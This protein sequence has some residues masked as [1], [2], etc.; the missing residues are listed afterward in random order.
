MPLGRY[1]L[2]RILVTIVVLFGVSVLTFSMVQFLPGN[3]V[4][5]ILQ[6]Q[7][8]SPQLKQQL[9]AQ[10]HLND[11]I[12]QQYLYWLNDALHLNFGES[13]ISNRVV[14]KAILYRL[15]NTVA[16]GLFGFLIAVVIGIPAG[17]VA[18]V[19]KGELADEVSRVGALLGIATPNFW[20]GLILLL[21]FS[22]WLGWFH[23][24]PPADKGILS[25]AMLHF[26]ILPA[27]TLGTAS[28]ALLMRLMRSSMLE[29][30][31]KDHV[32]TARAKGLSERTVIRKHVLRNSL[33]AV[34]TV[35]AL[36][37]A[38]LVDGAV[39]VEQ[40]FSW[41]G[42]GRLLVT[43]ITQRDFPIIQATVLFI[44][45]MIVLANLVA[46]LLYSVLDPRI[47]Y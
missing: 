46:D 27:I 24:I 2:K 30:I 3:A 19:R 13:L 44:A 4:D 29:Q 9:Y 39:V 5:Y 8:A 14:T 23:T 41:P 15:P 22:V 25:P 38:F 21:V 36:Q 11:P 26:L 35:A 32:R 28:A 45:T 42:L 40:V 10:Y 6:F 43:A 17:V 1:I 7:K 18:A 16:L 37:V 12:W 31:N 20:L 47:R 33:I 34:V